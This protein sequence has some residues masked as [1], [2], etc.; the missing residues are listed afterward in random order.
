MKQLMP[1]L[2]KTS[3]VSEYLAEVERTIA[4]YGHRDVQGFMD[5]ASTAH[6]GLNYSIEL[7]GYA[8]RV[9]DF[10]LAGQQVFVPDY[11]YFDAHVAVE[12]AALVAKFN[13]LNL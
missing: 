5:A 10:L 4:T 7:P 11:R 2:P 1:E 3:P 12:Y 13:S 9:R 8:V 6:Q